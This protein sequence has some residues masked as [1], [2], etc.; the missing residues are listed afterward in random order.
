ML[1]WQSLCQ[2]NLARIIAMEHGLEPRDCLRYLCV[3]AILPSRQPSDQV[4]V[5]VLMK[6][7]RKLRHEK[8]ILPSEATSSTLIGKLLN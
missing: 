2:L 4:A 8:V 6:Q 3:T 5:P 7:L 1:V